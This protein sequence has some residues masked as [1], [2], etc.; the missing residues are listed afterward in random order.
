MRTIGDEDA[1]NGLDEEDVQLNIEYLICG[2]F[3]TSTRDQKG[4]DGMRWM[5]LSALQDAFENDEEAL[6]KALEEWEE[7]SVSACTE[8]LRRLRAPA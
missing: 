8:A 3:R 1:R 6:D 5:A 4:N 2:H 7:R